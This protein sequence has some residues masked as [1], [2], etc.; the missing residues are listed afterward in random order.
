[1]NKDLRKRLRRLGVKD[2]KT[3]RIALMLCKAI[4]PQKPRGLWEIRPR[5]PMFRG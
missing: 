5:D 1:M 4:S 2:R 3:M